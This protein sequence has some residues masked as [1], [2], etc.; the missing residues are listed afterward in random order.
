MQAQRDATGSGEKSFCRFRRLQATN[1]MP[2]ILWKQF[3][4]DARC[5]RQHK[6]RICDSAVGT[7]SNRQTC[8][9]TADSDSRRRR[10]FICALGPRRSVNSVY[11]AQS[12]L[13]TQ[14]PA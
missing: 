2:T 7:T 14:S 8:R 11:T 1:K 4:E 13:F 10:F 6:P 9:I 12:R 5:R 3:H